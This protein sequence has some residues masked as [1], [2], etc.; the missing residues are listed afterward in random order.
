[1]EKEVKRKPMLSSFCDGLF[2]KLKSKITRVTFVSV[3]N[4]T[5]ILNGTVTT[6]STLQLSGQAI[7]VAGKN[8]LT[9]PT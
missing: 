8:D 9:L 2:P 3:T 4:V 6:S 7:S 5:F 1:M